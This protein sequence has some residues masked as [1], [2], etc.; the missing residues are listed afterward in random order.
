MTGHARLS[1][2]VVSLFASKGPVRLPEIAP[3]QDAMQTLAVKD[4]SLYVKRTDMF[5]DLFDSCHLFF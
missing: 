4:V 1:A 5:S 3:R 2:P